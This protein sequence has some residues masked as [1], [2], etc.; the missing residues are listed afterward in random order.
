MRRRR[1]WRQ[2]GC[3]HDLNKNESQLLA[4]KDLQK[5]SLERSS[6]RNYFVLI[7]ISLTVYLDD[8]GLSSAYTIVTEGQVCSDYQK[9]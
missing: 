8:S 6:S 3:T 4:K 7:N 1:R 2:S 5:N 9:R